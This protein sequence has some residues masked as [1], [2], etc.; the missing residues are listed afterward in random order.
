MLMS[1][2]IYFNRIE[3]YLEGTTSSTE[4]LQFE[5]DLQEDPDLQQEYQ[6][7]LATRVAIDDLAL[8]QVRSTV[9]QIAQQA[10]EAKTFRLSRKVMAMAASFLI[11]VMLMA[12]L[13][14]RQQYSDQQ[15]FVQQYE[16]PNWSPIRGSSTAATTYDQAIANMQSG[17]MQN[18]MDQLASIMPEEDVYV[19][20]QYALAHLQLQTGK[21][22]TAIETFSKIAAR[23][24]KRYQETTEWFLTLSYLKTE[25]PAKAKQ[26]LELIL[27][28]QQHPYYQDALVLQKQLASFW[29]RF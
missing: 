11:L 14:G 16:A 22:E 19:T 24:D 26:Q 5:K 25:L 3:S 7:Y 28:N 23:N 8:D 27:Q 17:N 9:A 20:A 13:Y 1:E 15:L 18:A 4:K 10:P 2:D 29:R 21:G 6:A 12:L